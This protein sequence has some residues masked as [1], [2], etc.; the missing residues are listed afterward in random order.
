MHV[1]QI[2]VQTIT[3]HR[4]KSSLDGDGPKSFKSISLPEKKYYTCFV[5]NISKVEQKGE[6]L[7]LPFGL[8]PLSIVRNVLCTVDTD[9]CVHLTHKS[10][11]ERLRLAL[12]VSVALLVVNSI[13]DLILHIDYD[14]NSD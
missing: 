6:P 1:Q 8:P 5:N 7:H 3:S 14:S 11:E 10:I 9:S 12:Q 2:A 4:L 13:L